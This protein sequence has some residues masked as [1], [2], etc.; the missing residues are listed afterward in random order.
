MPIGE[1]LRDQPGHAAR[2]RRVVRGVGHHHVAVAWEVL[3]HELARAWRR[4]GIGASRQDQRRPSL[5]SVVASAR[6]GR[7]PA[8]TG[9]A[10]RPRTSCR[11]PARRFGSKVDRGDRRHILRAEHRHG[12]AQRHVLGRTDAVRTVARGGARNRR[13]RPAR[14]IQDGRG[15]SRRVERAAKMSVATPESA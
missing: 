1:I 5:V 7:R 14:Q 4:D 12:G 11:I 10:R 2:E 8:R 3:R 6:E 13:P 9:R 15:V